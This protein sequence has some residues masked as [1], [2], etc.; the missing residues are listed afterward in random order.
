[1]P[2]ALFNASIA[3]LEVFFNSAGN[4][5]VRL[6]ELDE[7][8]SHRST[9]GATRL[10]ISVREAIAR[11]ENRAPPMSA[12]GFKDS[13]R[14]SVSPA[15]PQA[16]AAK[17]KI[18]ELRAQLLDLSNRNRLLNF[19][20]SARGARQVR[21][22]DESLVDLVRQLQGSGTAELVE[23]PALP[24]EPDD[25]ADEDFT[26]ALEEALL[27][28]KVYL[29]AVA[30][31]EAEGGDDA[32]AKMRKAERSL[33]DRLRKRLGMPSRNDASLTLQAHAGRF[34]I[35]PS[36]DLDGRLRSRRP[37][38]HWQTLLNDK[39][40]GRRL[41]GIVQQAD[42]S[43]QELGLETLHFVFGFLEWYPKTP[44]GEAD[45]PLFSPLLLQPMSI[46][47]KRAGRGSVRENG[48]QLIEDP[49]LRPAHAH[50]ETFLL[51][52]SDTEDLQVNLTLR[53]RLQ[54]EHQVALPD[55]DAEQLDVE[56]FLAQVEAAV[57]H[58][59]NWRIRKFATL[60]HLSFSR[61][62]MWL[63]LDPDAPGITPP[64]LHPV[65]AELFG[66]RE[67]SD[68]S[69]PDRPEPRQESGVPVLVTD[70][71]SSQY[72]AIRT[73]LGGRNLVIQGPPG[74]GKSQT[75]A[76]LIAAALHEGK[77]V[78]FVAEK[79]AALDVVQKRLEEAG[80]GSFLLELHSAKAG[81]KPVLESIRR[82]LEADARP[83]APGQ[84]EASGDVREQ[85]D[86]E[87][88]RL[89]AYADAV[90][91]LFGRCGMTVHELVW[92]NY[93]FR[94]VTLSEA[95]QALDL[96]G[97]EDFSK[98]D[99][100]DRQAAVLRWHAA[101]SQVRSETA[102]HDGT[103]PW[104]WVTADD[105]DAHGR[106]RLLGES[107]KLSRAAIAL[108]QAVNSAGLLPS[109]DPS[110]AQSK[111]L[112]HS[113][114]GLGGRPAEAAPGLWEVA[115][116]APKDPTLRR[117]ASALIAC[118]EA[119]A[120][121]ASQA[122]GA[123]TLGDELSP[124][125]ERMMVEVAAISGGEFQPDARRAALEEASE[126][127]DAAERSV[128]RLVAL[129]G[130]GDA[131]RV[132]VAE[133]ELCV[134]A[135]EL[136]AEVPARLVGRTHRLGE[137]GAIQRARKSISR[138]RLL[139]ERRSRAEKVLHVGI[140][141]ISTDEIKS[142]AQEFAEGWIG[143]WLF[144]G[145][146]RAACRFAERVAPALAA[147]QRAG[148]FA[149][150]AALKTEE[151]AW[152]HDAAGS[153]MG[154]LCDGVQTDAAALEAACEWVE[155]VRDG[156][157]MGRPL[158]SQLRTALFS[159][160]EE[161]QGY[162]AEIRR[163][164]IPE[165][166]R[167][168]ARGCQ[169]KDVDVFTL[170][171]ANRRDLLALRTVSGKLEKLQWRGPLGTKRLEQLRDA[172]LAQAEAQKVL[173]ANATL[174]SLLAPDVSKRLA[175]IEN[176]HA[177]LQRVGR[178][179]LSPRWTERLCAPGSG[180][181]W[182]ELNRVQG[183]LAKH[184]AEV[185]R[186]FEAVRDFSQNSDAISA[187]QSRRLPEL[188]EALDQLVQHPDLLVTRAQQ[189]VEGRRMDELGL[190]QFRETC[191]REWDGR[192][193]AAAIA[194]RLECLLIRSLCRRAL[195]A[196][197]IFHALRHASPA[198]IRDRFRKLDAELKIT[199][200]LRVAE[201]LLRRPIPRGVGVG[202]RSQWTDLALLSHTVGLERP[203]ISLRELV[204]RAGGALQALKP[205]F[206][207]SPLSVAQLV[208]RN[209]LQFDLVIFDEASQ[210]RPEDALSALARSRQFVVV[211]DPMQLPPT[212]FGEKAVTEADIDDE[213][214]GDETAVVESI[215]ETAAAAYPGHKRLLWHYR[216]QDP[217][218]IAFPNQEFY[219]RELKLFPAPRVRHPASGIKYVWVGGTYSARTNLEEAKRCANAAVEFMRSY[220]D[221]SLGIVALNRPQADLIE[222]ELGKLIDE[223]AH[224]ADYRTKWAD[225]LEP[226]FVKNLE[227]VQGDERDVIFV[228]TVFGLDE[229]GS[230][231]QRFGP[232]NSKV[233]HRRLNVLFTR[234]KHQLV[235]FTSLP[236]EEIR[237]TETSH[238]GV[239][240][241]K[242]YLEF[243]RSGRLETG[244]SSG[245]P[246]DSAFEE[247]V[248]IE[249]EA[250]GYPCEPQVGVAGFFIDLGV[251][252]PAS[253]E[254]FIMG[255]ECDGAGYHTSRSARDR[256]RLRQE[257][258]ER[259]GWRI[260]RIWSTDWFSNPRGQM[261]RLLQALAQAKAAPLP[262]AERVHVDFP[263]KFGSARPARF[264]P[265]SDHE[266]RSGAEKTVQSE[267]T[268][269]LASSAFRSLLEAELGNIKGSPLQVLVE[270][271]FD[272]P[273]E[274]P[275]QPE[276][277]S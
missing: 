257:I 157:P 45:E 244:R 89:H 214:D 259:M 32:E 114:E 187:W 69:Q 165:K 198:S 76:N 126:D 34:G 252:H 116:A 236:P 176:I 66:G 30:R 111:A 251:R 68:A 98:D 213:G 265:G 226:L 161:L 108:A 146:F 147:D 97:C 131:G 127:F 267:W 12:A 227:N 202:L 180:A 124:L 58:L 120:H 253:H 139:Q 182:T 272:L 239:R 87:A 232:I 31:I 218:L 192:V 125:L 140:D 275:S 8:L 92:R 216:S 27:T 237:T 117:V 148:F 223:T 191:E 270:E 256:D 206:M 246:A 2:R 77:S 243:A 99:L 138:L 38:R 48:L 136:A 142:A 56:R 261:E 13:P 103:H 276:K 249:L 39:E 53:V 36:Y 149:D 81:K 260:H 24:D 100:A 57:G 271:A 104:N 49:E 80:L 118:E 254:H 121:V 5:L 137:V 221:R 196:H 277:C 37:A 70:C 166:L 150:L 181:A 212:S 78:L 91:S 95:Q 73:A 72:D 141:E 4:D 205:C 17:L 20:H 6:Q 61:L 1:M 153:E 172:L 102:Q 264:L 71:D 26:T 152:L 195:A 151:Q 90:N 162:A 164:D 274:G 269:L 64:H 62:P 119:T 158:G 129:A 33:R 105:L 50:G 29:K 231:F 86:G 109:G 209:R 174:A 245:R 11:L 143:S 217:S 154:E 23:L 35:N 43:R 273:S 96:P 18:K 194:S 106:E 94:K 248:R 25:E 268:V 59:P 238:W 110:F 60:T 173:D 16:L 128:R 112:L 193:D 201:R 168:M 266:T 203:R 156:L 163:E 188:A 63:D 235:L 171:E 47:R 258:L 22:V 175:N 199:D 234:A 145:R 79:M 215:L 132:T 41:R 255:I 52:A 183:E 224:A 240:A 21:V 51:S 85:R 15:S 83:A 189:M 84:T 14:N 204:K 197:P 75:I 74:T 233:G 190:G 225:G 134:R 177:T 130:L 135:L 184:L 9:S 88:A 10:R 208:D 144:N 170:A 82:R 179:G 219:G 230:F 93:R 3:Q 122:P 186:R 167:R 200:R 242:Q 241:L 222:L 155:E 178:S 65:L 263:Q 107:R 46:E 262:G 160:S 55:L 185:D 113:L 247:S 28:D 250:A 40:L 228:S 19:K 207:M 44:D 101:E 7:E 220:P 210:V 54:Q 211:G 115:A 159:L 67:Q 42:E 123:V 229:K 169:T 133:L